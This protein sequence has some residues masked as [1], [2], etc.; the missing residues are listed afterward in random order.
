MAARVARETDD[1][2]DSPLQRGH[3]RYSVTAGVNDLQSW[4]KWFAN[5]HKDLC[6]WLYRMTEE[7]WEWD[8]TYETTGLLVRFFRQSSVSKPILNDNWNMARKQAVETYFGQLG[9][10]DGD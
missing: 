1:Q 7:D 2:L 10:G 3:P 9:G 5:V 6:Q 8:E 4:V